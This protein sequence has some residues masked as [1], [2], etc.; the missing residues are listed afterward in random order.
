MTAIASSQA[1]SQTTAWNSAP[2]QFTIAAAPGKA[3]GGSPGSSKGG[4]GTVPVGPASAT[5]SNS[6]GQMLV[7]LANFPLGTTHY[8]CHSGSGYPTGGAITGQG[9]VNIT[10]PGESLGELCSG[11]GNF[12]IGFQ[13]TDGH[14][15][16]S[17]QVTL[18]TTSVTATA[19][20]GQMLVQLANFPLGTT[21]YFC[22]SGSGYPTG[23]TIVS[24]SS[25]D[26][27]SAN[28]NLGALCSGSG[29]FWIGFQGTDGHDYY[30][31]QV[32]LAAA[33]PPAAAATAS[34]SQLQV[35]LA[36]F[37][38]GTTYYFCHSGTGYPTGGSIASHSSVDITSAN[39]NLGALCSGSGNFW[40]GFQGT[41]GH[42]YYSNQV[43]LG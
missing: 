5:V 28:E 39:E 38:L 43:T 22:H 20:S 23:G 33:S 11:S 30:S 16:Y 10:S 14:D 8:F 27:T 21:Y 26:I 31:N 35:Q 41:D 42:D 13:G 6:N 25:V 1:A 12:W 15:Y 29:N 40:I 37:P 2:R 24:H 3:A 9:A 17:N 19:S 32:T 18:G 4:G 36:N 7:R 34:G